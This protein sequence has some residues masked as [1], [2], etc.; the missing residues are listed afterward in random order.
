MQYQKMQTVGVTKTEDVAVPT[1][2]VPSNVP[3]VA[4]ATEPK[5]EGQLVDMNYSVVPEEKEAIQANLKKAGEDVL[6]RFGLDTKGVEPETYPG[7]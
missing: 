1:K 2:A 5:W 6:K 3:A 7:Q 4:S